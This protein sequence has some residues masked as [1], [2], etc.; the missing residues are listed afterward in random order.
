MP[1]VKHTI[2]IV[3]DDAD[4]RDAIRDAFLH[5][6]QQQD[7]GLISNGD[8]LLKKLR[9]TPQHPSLILLDLNMPGKDG[10]TI[11]EE[12][13][14]D[15]ELKHI[16]VVVLTTSSSVKEKNAVYKLGANCFVT[17]PDTFSQFIKITDSIA[18]LWLNAS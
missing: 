18:R 15:K 12:I 7:F 2:F 6:K 4:D 5:N 3:D 14:T 10:K 17:K 9:S 13:K 8:E 11:L 1:P 16:P